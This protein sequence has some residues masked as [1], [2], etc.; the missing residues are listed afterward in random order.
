MITGEQV[1]AAWA[2]LGWSIKK[3]AY[4]AA[5]AEETL[6]LFENGPGYLT[7]L[8][9]DVLHDVLKGAGVEFTNDVRPGVRLRKKRK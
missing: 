5:L 8:H 2:L 3:L 4:R 7:S 9:G 6:E 1:K